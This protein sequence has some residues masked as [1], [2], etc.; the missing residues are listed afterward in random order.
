M[1]SA[2]EELGKETVQ[3]PATEGWPVVAAFGVSLLWAGLLTHWM[4]SLLGAVC[5]IAGFVNWFREVLP[6][7]AH[8]PVPVPPEAMEAEVPIREVRLFASRRTGAPRAIAA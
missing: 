2:N 5:F 8:E 7:E 1:N 3:V 6:R 4:V